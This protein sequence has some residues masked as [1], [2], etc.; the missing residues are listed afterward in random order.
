MPCVIDLSNE[1]AILIHGL[2]FVV[3]VFSIYIVIKQINIIVSFRSFQ[4]SFFSYMYIFKY[5]IF[6]ILFLFGYCYCDKL[7]FII[8]K[9]MYFC[10]EQTANLCW[11]FL[12]IIFSNF[13][14]NLFSNLL[15]F[16]INCWCH[17]PVRYFCY[18]ISF[19]FFTQHN[20]KKITYF[21]L[22]DCISSKLPIN[23]ALISFIAIN[24]T[25]YW[26]PGTFAIACVL[27]DLYA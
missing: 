16:F 19:W 12:E 22:M 11:F 23:L 20:M 6:L 24:L 14:I 17:D 8:S 1:Y 7:T 15:C 27:F 3:F 10:A 18:S 25:S 13:S 5:T 9:L 21:V 2:D 4:K 26:D